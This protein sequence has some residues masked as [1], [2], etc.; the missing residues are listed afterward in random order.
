VERF[1]TRT[2]EAARSGA[3]DPASLLLVDD[4]DLQ[5]P[6]TNGRLLLLNSLGWRVVLTAGFGAGV[7]QRVPL[8]QNAAGGQGPGI[9]IAPRGTL[10]GELCG[11]R[12]ETEPNHPPGRAVVIAD[13]R[14]RA[15]QLA[16]DP[17]ADSSNPGPG[18]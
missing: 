1:W 14:A 13:G 18:P 4:L 10:D 16:V 8:L 3:L 6:E 17:A 11:V 7:R 12:C 15:V 5:S 9:L 2:Q